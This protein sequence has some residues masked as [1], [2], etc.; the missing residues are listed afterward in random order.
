VQHLGYLPDV[1]RLELAMR[2]AYNAADAAPIAPTALQEI[3]PDRLMTST[4]TLAPATQL[5]R[6]DWP[7]Y[8]IWAFNMI[9][10]EKPEMRAEDVLITRPEFDPQPVALPPC[11]GEFVAS[12]IAGNSFGTALDAA[13]G[14]NDQFDLSTTLA[15]L[16]SGGA[17]TKIKEG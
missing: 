16:L 11:G 7:L 10:G 15:A 12:L 6:S 2:A 17:I 14:R 9:D 13:S 8:S 1:A 4:F 5:I 3:S